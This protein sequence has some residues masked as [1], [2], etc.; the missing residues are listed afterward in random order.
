MSGRSCQHTEIAV[1]MDVQRRHEGCEVVEQ[2]RQGQD[3]RTV[4]LGSGF[5]LSESR[6]SGSSSLAPLLNHGLRHARQGAAGS[7]LCPDAP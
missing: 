7:Q 4:P 5:V 3:Q 1:A 2:V 6:R